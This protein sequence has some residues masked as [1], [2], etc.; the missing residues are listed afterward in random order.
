L[1]LVKSTAVA[2][3]RWLWRPKIRLMLGISISPVVAYLVVRDI[4]WGALVSQ[5]HD[6]PLRYAL[7]SLLIFTMAMALR[8]YRWHVLFVGEKVPIHR[9]LLVQNAGIGLNSLSPIRVISEA[10]QY[11]LLTL[12]YPV[13]KEM[14]AATLGV[15]RILDF[16]IGAL[17][18]GVGLLLLPGLK[19]FALY[20]LGAGVLA[21]VSLAAVP[22]VIWVGTRPGFTSLP[23]LASASWS[24]RSLVRARL[25][26]TFSFLLTLAYWLTAGLSAWVLAYGMGIE[27]SLLFATLLVIGT[28]TFVALVPS[29]PASVGTFEFAV[30]YL[31]TAFGIGPVEALGYALVIHAI[32]FIP[33]ILIALMVLVSWPLKRSP[34]DTVTHGPLGASS[35]AVGSSPISSPAAAL[36]EGPDPIHL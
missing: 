29:L 12:R 5:F 31:L 18:L 20:V 27:I 15:Q 6:F 21:I 28:L 32:I 17:L 30:Y 36:D 8:G 26:L 19:G 2:T 4:A 35:S 1:R 23:L 24:L 34:L 25:K 16:V 10:V 7:A 14:V 22:V 3:L 33:P 13:K 11:L 9:L